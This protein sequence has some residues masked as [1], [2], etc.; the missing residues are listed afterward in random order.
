VQA[1]L[2]TLLF[3][4]FF[5]IGAAAVTGSVLFDDLIRYCRNKQLLASAEQSLH[6]LQALNDDYDALIRQLQDDPNLI[7]RLAPA[8]LGA[9]RTDPNTA[10]PRL[11]PQQLD[12]ARKALA[13]QPPSRP[14]SLTQ[15]WLERLNR[16]WRRTAL[17]LCGTALI[18]IS[19][20]CFAPPQKPKPSKPK[21]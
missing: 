7:R 16:P 19:L 3:V 13:E 9:G 10:Y 4:V 8:T 5:S 21:T 2:R 1:I 12:A 18:I 14:P 11:T 17:F 20:A 6:K 15:R